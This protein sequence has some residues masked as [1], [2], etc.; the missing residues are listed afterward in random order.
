VPV[1]RCRDYA[2][3]CV[4][5]PYWGRT[6]VA[7]KKTT[8]IRALSAASMMPHHG[9]HVNL[10]RRTQALT[11]VLRAVCQQIS[12]RHTP[13]SYLADEDQASEVLLHAL[14]GRERLP[15]EGKRFDIV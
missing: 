6:G 3:T 2:G 12:G 1:Q 9:R 8:G 5:P 14:R 15:C 11:H 4:D 13:S 10:D 7:V